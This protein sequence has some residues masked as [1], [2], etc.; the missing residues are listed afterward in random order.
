MDAIWRSVVI[1]KSF[2]LINGFLI[3]LSRGIVK[4]QLNNQGR[5]AP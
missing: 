1:L 5:E 3:F 4:K 2:Q